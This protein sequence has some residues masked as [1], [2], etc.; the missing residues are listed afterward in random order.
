MV[1]ACV[2][3][4]A[5]W[6]ALGFADRCGGEMGPAGCERGHGS[7]AIVSVYR[8]RNLVPGR[9]TRDTTTWRG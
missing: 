7:L 2:C 5:T 8:S 9:S 4:K 6:W 1:E 3:R